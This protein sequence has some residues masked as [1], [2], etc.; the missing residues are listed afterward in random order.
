M[1]NKLPELWGMIKRS[2]VRIHQVGEGAEIK[3]KG[4]EKNL[5]N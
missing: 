2:N 3:I 4:I 5:F 1:H